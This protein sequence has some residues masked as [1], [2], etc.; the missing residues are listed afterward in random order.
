MNIMNTKFGGFGA[1]LSMVLI[2]MLA[3]AGGGAYGYRY[4]DG[5]MAI[6][7]AKKAVSSI[8][9]HD[10]D[11]SDSQTVNDFIEDANKELDSAT[12][13]KEAYEIL[14]DF[15][16]DISKIMTKSEKEL[17]KARQKKAD[18]DR[19]NN[20]NRNDT[21]SQNGMTSDIFNQDDESRSSD[22][23]LDKLIGG[24]KRQN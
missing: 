7:D 23:V 2:L 19:Y 13:R 16:S 15:N 24:S 3:S 10:Y 22:G 17:A 1:K 6:K 5:K 20:Y 11:S 8:D 21:R 9:V 12:T 4:F 14:S 18:S